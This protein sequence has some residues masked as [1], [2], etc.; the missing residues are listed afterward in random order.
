M[1]I[2]FGNRL[3]ELRQEINCTQGDLSKKLNVHKGTISNWENGHRFPDEEVLVKLSDLFGCSLDYLL[4]RTDE[5][6]MFKDIYTGKELSELVPE[7]WRAAI[8]DM[9]YLQFYN[10]IKKE[11]INSDDLIKAYKVYQSIKENTR[12]TK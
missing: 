7:E 12:D 3:K 6:T 10:K 11:D 5:K 2:K 8:S 4:G 9:Q 1:K